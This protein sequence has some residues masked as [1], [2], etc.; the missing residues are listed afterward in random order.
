M[1]VRSIT[2]Y[3]KTGDVLSR[4]NQ[5]TFF[6][7]IVTGSNTIDQSNLARNALDVVHLQIT[8]APVVAYFQETNHS[9]PTYNETS[10]TLTPVT[11]G[12]D[13][14]G[15]TF[16]SITL[17]TGD[18]VR[19]ACRVLT[20]DPTLVDRAHDLYLFQP[21]LNLGGSWTAVGPRR[22]FS[23]SGCDTVNLAVPADDS[24]QHQNHTF[25]YLYINTGN[26]VALTGARLSML[27]D[28]TDNELEVARWSFSVIVYKH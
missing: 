15:F 2:P 16:T 19:I 28:D 26:N 8:S 18:M 4:D 23:M 1:A 6:G 14:C 3:L 25:N 27:I 21:Q 12:G 13:D 7:G 17:G 11:T 20:E 24:I 22:V 9:T 10:I 5:Q